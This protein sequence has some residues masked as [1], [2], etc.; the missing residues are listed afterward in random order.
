MSLSTDSSSTLTPALASPRLLIPKTS[1]ARLPIPAAAS[2]RLLTPG[3]Q[4]GGLF[5][6]NREYSYEVSIYDEGMDICSSEDID[7]SS[8]KYQW[9]HEG[10]VKSYFCYLEI[11]RLDYSDLCCHQPHHIRDIR[12]NHH[13]VATEFSVPSL[14]VSLKYN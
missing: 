5:A 3:M 13:T 1:S 6:I 4:G 12:L 8:P 7:M 9:L 11:E 10:G 14:D 2:P